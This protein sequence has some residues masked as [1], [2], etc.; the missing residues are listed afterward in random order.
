ML[1]SPRQGNDIA[2]HKTV[3]KAFKKLL[4]INIDGRKMIDFLKER[5]G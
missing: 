1:V 3:E 5:N 2:K 4:L